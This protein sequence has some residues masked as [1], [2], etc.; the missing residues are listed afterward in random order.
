MVQPSVQ[1]VL[2][3][4]SPNTSTCTGTVEEAEE[5]ILSMAKG[6]L[7]WERAILMSRRYVSGGDDE[8][9]AI[10]EGVAASSSS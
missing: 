4:E 3:R 5:L 9:L 2:V 6:R 10:T 8:A 7:S 1:Y